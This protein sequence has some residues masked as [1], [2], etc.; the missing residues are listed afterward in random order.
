[1]GKAVNVVQTPAYEALSRGQ[2]NDA[3]WQSELDGKRGISV[4]S[5]MTD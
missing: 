3:K 4:S 1:M 2:A 5:L